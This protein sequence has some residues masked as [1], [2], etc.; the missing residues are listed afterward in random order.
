LPVLLQNTPENQRIFLLGYFAWAR[1]QPM[2][3][4]R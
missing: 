2:M 3:Q 1:M 4:P